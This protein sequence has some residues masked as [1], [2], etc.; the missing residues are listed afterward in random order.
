MMHIKE[1]E[2][3]EEKVDETITAAVNSSEPLESIL[4]KMSFHI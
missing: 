1:E 2:E 3:E 4:I